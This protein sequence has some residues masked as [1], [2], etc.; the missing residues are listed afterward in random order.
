MESID[1]LKKQEK[2]YWNSPRVNKKW[3]RSIYGGSWRCLKLEG[4]MPPARTISVWTKMG[5]ERWGG[6]KEVLDVENHPITNVD[7]RKKLYSQLFK[8]ILHIKSKI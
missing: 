1:L 2:L 3:Y 7:S 5:D 4:K 6:Q 8:N